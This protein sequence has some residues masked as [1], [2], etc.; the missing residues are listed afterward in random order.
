MALPK[1]IYALSY[2]ILPSFHFEMADIQDVNLTAQAKGEEIQKEEEELT[3][4]EEAAST[5]V[6]HRNLHTEF[7]S[8]VAAFRRERAGEVLFRNGKLSDLRF[9]FDCM[10]RYAGS[11]PS[12]I[13]TR[14][15]CFDCYLL[16][17][18]LDFASLSPETGLGLTLSVYSPLYTSLD[19]KIGHGLRVFVEKALKCHVCSRLILDKSTSELFERVHEMFEGDYKMSINVVPCP[20]PTLKPKNDVL[21]NLFA[22]LYKPSE[23][24]FVMIPCRAVYHTMVDP[25][26]TSDK[27]VLMCNGFE[28]KE[29]N[30]W[31]QYLVQNQTKIVSKR[32]KSRYPRIEIERYIL[33]HWV[34][35]AMMRPYL[36][37]C[38]HC[39]H[40][41]QDLQAFK[42][43][44]SLVNIYM[45]TQNL[46]RDVNVKMVYKRAGV[47]K[48]I[49]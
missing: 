48:T 30:L 45:N 1:T 43:L 13:E 3:L 14:H 36:Y 40:G 17:H 19:L 37:Y 12:E 10:F 16:A 46:M 18:S 11:T 39:K 5:S 44:A 47:K 49:Q 41:E 35:Q 42:Q 4:F 26:D 38:T 34:R 31:F 23:H 28:T 24:V 22:Y 27:I 25:L 15:V 20:D 9:Y 33:F 7:H 6:P 29:H 21:L 8:A 2:L 32:F